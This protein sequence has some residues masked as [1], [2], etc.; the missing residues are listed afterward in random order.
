MC[1]VALLAVE[2]NRSRNRIHLD[3]LQHSRRSVARGAFSYQ[4]G[5]QESQEEMKSLGD[6]AP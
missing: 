3:H 4:L 5:L 2:T 1:W 6:V